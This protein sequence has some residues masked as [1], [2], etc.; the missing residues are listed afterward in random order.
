MTADENSPNS[1][2]AQAAG[3]QEVNQNVRRFLAKHKC[4][5]L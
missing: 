4:K 2:D 3:G 5:T 1:L